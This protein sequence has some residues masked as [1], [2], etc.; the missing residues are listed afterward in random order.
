MTKR[1]KDTRKGA[2]V[3]TVEKVEIQPP[4]DDAMGWVIIAFAVV[5]LIAIIILWGFILPGQPR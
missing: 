5:M 4:Q 1:K 3:F 2:E